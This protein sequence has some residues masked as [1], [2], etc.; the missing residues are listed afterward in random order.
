MQELGVGTAGNRILTSIV[1]GRN[2]ATDMS[3]TTGLPDSGPSIA[4]L[5]A[6]QNVRL[7]GPGGD[8][9]DAKDKLQLCKHLAEN[10]LAFDRLRI[11]LVHPDHHQL[12]P[13]D[14]GALRVAEWL[15]G[16]KL[17]LK[18]ETDPGYVLPQLDRPRYLS[19]L[20]GQW[21]EIYLYNALLAAG[22]DEVRFGQKV[23]WRI[24]DVV[25]T[26]E[27]DTIGR[28]GE[29]LVLVSCKAIS[30]MPVQGRAAEL[31]DFLFEAHYWNLHFA[32]GRATTIVVTTADRV[33]E[34]RDAFPLR[35]PPT[36][37]QADI[38]EVDLLGIEDLGWARLVPLLIE[39]VGDHKK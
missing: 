1:L 9:D 11:V 10:F 33:D 18:S 16:N 2:S 7:L 35:F 3:A 27:V 34:H 5:L 6:I 29:Q 39:L 22:A 20:N 30:P 19:F 17:L 12:A 31:R 23:E 13:N 32:K 28:F 8:P 21:L 26:N 14:R 25:G 37:K 36:E 24:D 4:G 38:L 15:V